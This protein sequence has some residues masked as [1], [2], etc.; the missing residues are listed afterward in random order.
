MEDEILLHQST[1]D[2]DTWVQEPQVNKGQD[3]D[4][5]PSNSNINEHIDGENLI[6]DDEIESIILQNEADQKQE[7]KIPQDILQKIRETQ[8]DKDKEEKQTDAAPAGDSDPGIDADEFLDIEIAV[9]ILDMLSAS[10][11]EMGADKMGLPYEEDE[12][13]AS[14]KQ[15]RLL[16]K[17]AKRFAQ[18]QKIKGSPLGLMI[19][20]WFAVYG[21]NLGMSWVNEKKARKREK[22][23]FEQ[24]RDE[25]FNT[26]QGKEYVSRQVQLALDQF[27]KDMAAQGNVAYAASLQQWPK[28]GRPKGSKDKQPRKKAA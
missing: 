7:K 28:G 1:Q 12:F 11:C 13:N 17:C 16:E 10:G 8:S 14:P 18:S 15:I 5:A 27:K 6:N 19:G 23:A 22:K 2:K 4:K 26:D 3:R 20:A 21:I 9:E 25:F 24:G